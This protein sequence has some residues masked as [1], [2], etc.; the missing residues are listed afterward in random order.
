MVDV[1]TLPRGR[2]FTREDLDALPDDGWRHELIDGVLVMTPAPSSRHQDVVLELAVLLRE[3]CP[4]HLKVMIAPFD[5]ALAVDTV[6]QPDVL[7]AR[8]RDVTDRD[9]PTAPVLA[10]EVLSP[11]TRRL[12]LT[13]KKSRLAEAGCPSYWAVDPGAGDQPVRLVSWELRGSEYVEVASVEGD[14]TADLTSPFPVSVT[15]SRLLG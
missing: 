10:V 15:P 4:S 3:N 1:T 9:L 8:R 6:V 14:E 13:L 5:V 2:T 12:D 11:S 7:V